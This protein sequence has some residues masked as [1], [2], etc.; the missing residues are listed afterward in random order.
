[1][2]SGNQKD[3]ADGQEPSA[4]MNADD[5]IYTLF[6]HKWLIL[7]FICLGAAG[8]C[9]VRVLRPPM[10]VSQAKLN[11]PYVKESGPTGSGADTFKPTG[12]G[13]QSVI[14][15]EVEIL[16][17]LDVA[18]N[19]AWKIGP[20]KI[21]AKRGGG[22]DV[23]SAAGL[24]CSGIDVEASQQST[25][26]TVAFRH[27][28][29]AVVQPVLNSII[30]MY[31]QKHVAVHEKLGVLD[32]YYRTRKADLQKQLETTQETLK[33]LK[34]EARTLVPDDSMHSYQAQLDRLNIELQQADRELAERKA[35]LGVE[36]Q[37]ALAGGAT[38]NPGP[39]VT[40]EVLEQYTSLHA[41]L[42][43]LKQRERESIQQHGLKEMH[44]TM[45]TIREQMEKLNRSKAGLVKAYPSLANVVISTQG[46]TNSMGTG[47]AADLADIKRLMTRVAVLGAQI[48]VVQSNATVLAELDPKIREA[49]LQYAMDSTNLLNV[50]LEMQGRRVS[51]NMGPGKVLNI[52]WVQSPTP[53]T[54]DDKK[55]KKK[56][57]TVFGGCVALGFGLAFLI[58][59]LLDRSI[60]RAVD[61]ERR[62]KLPVFLAIPDTT[63][64]SRARLRLPWRKNGAHRRVSENGTVAGANALTVWEPVHHLQAYTNGLCER[65]MTY[66]EVKDM[67]LK[68]PKL[69][70]V[71]ACGKGRSGV[72]TLA[73]GLA[74][75][76][77][78]TGNGNVLLVDMTDQQGVAQ[79]FYNGKPGCGLSEVLEPENRAEA[80][81]E[82][83]LFVASMQ[84]EATSDNA[85][86]A[87]TGFTHLMPKIKGSDYDYIIFDMPPVSPTSS[88]PR[89]TSYM[90]IVL[91]V[92]EAEKTGQQTAARANALMRDARANVAA[93]LNKCRPH[94]PA[95][96]SQEL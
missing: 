13:A 9:M 3:D 46:G 83:N 14:N 19:V 66:F 20:A 35:V 26:M 32:D 60:K 15:S 75:A 90:D 63:W 86:V 88:T 21:L 76:L 36:G 17:S 33:N 84:E 89:M 79:S 10:Y 85:K 61:V 11:I 39:P 18:S 43:S 81:V 37:A 24:V 44:P 41:D 65:L 47:F 25:I 28:D 56:L 49:E 53:A 50:A 58:E 92:L 38:N 68:K 77:S 72:T 62:L 73:S 82:Q 78:K 45:M 59:M 23:M 27:A 30:E 80:Q 74:A 16:R 34:R 87:P 48:A 96:L 12:V 29:D 95:L 42:A 69:V 22:T 40:P 51:E 8:A 94:V 31:M 54:L 2:L 91:L 4:G 6:R 64:Q 5:V 55:L 7:A 57:L 1:M 71:T 93:V 52:G 67:N 70:G